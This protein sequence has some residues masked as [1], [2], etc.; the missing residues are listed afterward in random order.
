[1]KVTGLNC[2][3]NAT[4]FMYFLERDDAFELPGYLKLEAWPGP[5]TAQA[6]VTYDPTTTD[7]EAVKQAITEPYY[8]AVGEVWRPSPFEIEGYDPLGW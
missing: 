5:G 8:D 2:R 3:G 4:L 6:R 1:L 7:T